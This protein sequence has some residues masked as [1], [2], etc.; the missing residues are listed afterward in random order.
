MARDVVFS[1]EVSK[2]PFKRIEN[3]Q[4]PSVLAVKTIDFNKRLNVDS[5]LSPEYLKAKSQ[6][7]LRNFGIITN[8]NKARNETLNQSIV[9][10]TSALNTSV[11]GN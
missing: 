2:S 5:N 9:N 6:L 11:G 8:K 3:E 1:R 7:P 10:G 4:P